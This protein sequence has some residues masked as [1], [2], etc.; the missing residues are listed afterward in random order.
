MSDSTL[1]VSIGRDVLL[2]GG[3]GYRPMSTLRWE[4]FQSDARLIVI[5]QG[6]IIRFAGA[7][8]GYW[9]GGREDSY[10]IVASVP[11]NK[12]LEL[13]G[14]YSVLAHKYDQEAVALTWGE[15]F[16]ATATPDY[17]VFNL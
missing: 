13:L 6:G 7:G 5:E 8:R 3:V 16:M 11:N 10:T 15:T 12:H 17:E 4:D 1:T 14:E 9:D 2:P